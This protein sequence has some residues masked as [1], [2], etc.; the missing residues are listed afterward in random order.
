MQ[1]RT[2]MGEENDVNWTGKNVVLVMFIP[3]LILRW[4]LVLNGFEGR[5]SWF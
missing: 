1:V 3:C 2:K 4:G 5:S